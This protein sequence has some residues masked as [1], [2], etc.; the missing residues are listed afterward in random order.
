MMEPNN[1]EELARRY[2]LPPVPE[3]VMRLTEMVAHQDS[4]LGEIAAMIDRE[5]VLRKRLL[6][7]SNPEAR[8]EAEYS[9]DTVEAA[10]FQRGIGSALLLAMGTPLAFALASTFQTMLALKLE[11]VEASRALP[12]TPPFV[13][14]AIGFSGRAAGTVCLR[15]SAGSAQ[16][17][18]ARIL[19]VN[20]SELKDVTEVND[21][22]G[23][24][25]N[26][27]TGNFKSNLCDAGLDCH[28]EPPRVWQTSE[29]HSIV[30]PGGG[31]ERM[32][33]RAGQIGLAVEVAVNPWNQE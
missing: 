16:L 12:L 30:V 21:A 17:I 8:S 13:I 29:A 23:E 2:G 5:P 20:P 4:D 3:S 6:R 18:A 11:S 1:Y 26:I 15:L 31:L 32:A 27:I 28:L 33:F 24:L 14:G 25:L 10:L 22:V 7:L 9:L 19:G